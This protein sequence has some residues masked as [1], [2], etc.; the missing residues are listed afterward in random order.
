[1]ISNSST[2]SELI[3]ILNQR[4]FIHQSTDLDV[5]NSELIKGNII[6]YSGFDA[7][8]DSLH[9]GHLL[10]IMMLRWIQNTGN[11]PIV[12]I[13]GGTTKVG[14]PSG[15]DKTREILDDERI[16]NNIQSIKG[17]FKNFLNFNSGDNKATIL[18]NSEWLENLSYIDFLREFGKHF[19]VNRMLTMESVK[20]RIER[21]QPLTF[22]EFNYMILQAYDFIEL[23]KK[24]NCNLQIGGS[25]Q[26]G[27][28]VTGINLGKRILGTEL[29]G[30]TC[31]LLTTS[32]GQ[33]MGKTANGA[34][35][36]NSNKLAPYDYYQY[37]RN[38][39]DL[40][41]GKFLHLFTELPLSE[42]EKLESL[43]NE[44]IN[45]AKKI[46]AFE[47][48]KI[49]HG[50]NAAKNAEET[51]ISTYDKRGSG[52]DLPRIFFFF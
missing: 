1:M 27:N 35:W 36:L 49:L 20:Q 52:E 15:K 42:I 37:W 31:P 39:E 2:K 46:L 13:G 29:H 18:N 8:A 44:E 41:V 11:K 19:S 30:I 3:N 16:N 25:D 34:I 51:A 45:E 50:E 5:L 47:T 7:T 4:G 38:T 17:T 26:W 9:V 22:L 10:P 12:L 32:S 43:K 40:D 48:T 23:Y 21:E 28:I 14:D 33:K 6:A 24:H